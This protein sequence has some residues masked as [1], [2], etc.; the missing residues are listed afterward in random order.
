MLKKILF[1]TIF[2][3][4]FFLRIQGNVYN[5]AYLDDNILIQLT[6][7]PSEE[8]AT[9]TLLVAI[10][11]QIKKLDAV[12]EEEGERPSKLESDSDSITF[13][14]LM[15]YNQLHVENIFETHPAFQRAYHE[16]SLSIKHYNQERL[17]SARHFLENSYQ[18]LTI[19]KDE[20][21]GIYQEI[22]NPYMSQEEKN[23]IRPYI[24]PSNHPLKKKLDSIFKKQRATLNSQTFAQAGFICKYIQP[25][26]F[27]QVASHPTMPGYLFKVYL[28]SEKRIK[29]NVPGWKWFVRRAQNAEKIRSYIIRKGIKNFK[30]P[31]KWIYPLPAD[32]SPPNDPLYVRKNEIL[33]VEDMQ[34][35]SKADNFKAWKTVITKDILDELLKIIKYVGGKS[36]RPDNV[37]YTKKGVFAFIDTEYTNKIPEVESITPYLSPEM[38]AYWIKISAK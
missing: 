21:F 23:L 14:W 32:P 22:D 28:D 11:E 20:S 15:A 1:P 5:Q 34:L 24:I 31:K 16:Y 30:A 25:R 19:A 8:D 17:N 13:L 38:K 6:N 10:Q 12:I 4:I 26:S 2:L 36:Y 27:I 37:P 9:S 29:K 35:V 33:V 18:L 3:L 7:S